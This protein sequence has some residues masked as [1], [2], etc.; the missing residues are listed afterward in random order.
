MSF[1]SANNFLDSK[2]DQNMDMSTFILKRARV[3]EQENGSIKLIVK[4]KLG[5]DTS[6]DFTSKEKL[7]EYLQKKDIDIW[8]IEYS[9]SSKN[10]STIYKY[11]DTEELI[12][13]N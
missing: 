9:K 1:F 8:K 6:R 5:I 2:K 11:N 12:T 3:N 10:P 13:F 7:E 4:N